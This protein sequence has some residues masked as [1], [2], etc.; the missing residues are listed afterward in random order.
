MKAEKISLPEKPVFFLVSV[1]LITLTLSFP[2]LSSLLLA[3]FPAAFK[4]IEEE[5]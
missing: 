5:R 1:T 3:V 4:L 2:L